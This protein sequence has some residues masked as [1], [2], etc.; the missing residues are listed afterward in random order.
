MLFNFNYNDIKPND[1]YG[2]LM[3]GFKDLTVTG[4]KIAAGIMFKKWLASDYFKTKLGPKLENFMQKYFGDNL[5]NQEFNLE[6]LYNDSQQLYGD[7]AL[8]GTFL[9]KTV[10]VT[11]SAIV[12]KYLTELCGEG[13]G[14]IHDNP[15]DALGFVPDGAKLIYRASVT[16]PFETG[17]AAARFVIDLDLFKVLTNTS[18][19]LF[20]WMYDLFF[21]GVPTATSSIEAPKDPQLPPMRNSGTGAADVIKSI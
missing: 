15:D 17:A 11:R 12:E 3:G 16:I 2:A 6:Q 13:A 8:K 14:W 9:D 19:G 20:G 18:C 21:S 10:K 4:V 7:L 1:F 5:T